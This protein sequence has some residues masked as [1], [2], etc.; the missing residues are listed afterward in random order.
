MEAHGTPVTTIEPPRGW[1]FPD[2]RELWEHRDLVYF[3]ARRDIVTRYRQ[4]VVGTFWVILQPLLLAVAFSVFFGLLQKIDGPPGVPYPV[5]AVTGMVMWIAF[6]SAVAMGSDSAVAS[7]TLISKIYLPRIAIPIAAVIPSTLD[8]AL[9][10]VV[11]VAITLAYGIDPSIKIL[12]VPVAWSLALMT[13]LGVVLWLSALNV[14]YRDIG[15]VVPFAILVGLFISPIIYPFS[16]IPSNLQAAYSLNPMVGVLELY[17][18]GVLGTEFPGL[19]LLIPV[20]ISV[21]LLITGALYFQ[22]AQRSFADV[23]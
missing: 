22:R 3:L 19:L 4:A 2:L 12:I 14:R 8:F 11:V 21:T 1:R 16:S 20:V 15:Q 10:F 7:E 18:W 9:G 13:A 5:F 23:I 6:T 17:R